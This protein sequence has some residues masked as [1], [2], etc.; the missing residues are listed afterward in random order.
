MCTSLHASEQIYLNFE[1]LNPKH[2][3]SNNNASATNASEELSVASPR[4]ITIYIR[5]IYQLIDIQTTRIPSIVSLALIEEDRFRGI[6]KLS[7]NMKKTHNSKH[8]KQ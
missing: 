1:Q 8:A 6:V 5:V 2:S 7:A 4:V 3:K